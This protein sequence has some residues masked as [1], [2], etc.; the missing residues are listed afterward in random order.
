L[1]I[2]RRRGLLWAALAAWIA[3]AV[4]C[5][6]PTDPQE[7][8]D[9]EW[10]GT[11]LIDNQEIPIRL[12]IAYDNIDRVII[13]DFEE[14]I[15]YPLGNSI[16]GDRFKVYIS[17]RD[18]WLEGFFRSDTEVEGT[19]HVY[20]AVYSWSAIKIRTKNGRLLVEESYFWEPHVEHLAGNA[21][22]QL[23]LEKVD[24][25]KMVKHR[26]RLGFAE[27]GN[28]LLVYIGDLNRLA[29]IVRD[30]V[31]QDSMSFEFDGIRLTLINNWKYPFTADDL[32]EFWYE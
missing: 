14:K 26:Y 24:L 18:I 16:E 17:D 10:Y 29:Y 20:G 22:G 7:R 15:L 6:S 23:L 12:R 11:L 5:S 31:F 1:S 32:Y 30:V 28:E 9:G 8:Y 19:F 3:L 21:R 2:D 4:G 13:G 25:K 27:R